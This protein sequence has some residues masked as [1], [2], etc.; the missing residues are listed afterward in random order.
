MDNETEL[1][2]NLEPVKNTKR[3][4]GVKAGIAKAKLNGTYTG[5]KPRTCPNCGYSH[6]I[7]NP[8]KEPK[9]EKALARIAKKN[10]GSMP[11]LSTIETTPSASP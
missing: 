9:N 6:K 4:E 3:S 7:G 1:K 8:C 5:G 11:S 10:S 2:T